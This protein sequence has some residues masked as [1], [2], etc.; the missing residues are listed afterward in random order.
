[1]G[2]ALEKDIVLCIDTGHF[3]P[4]GNVSDKLSSL[5]FIKYLGSMS[6]AVEI[7]DHVILQDDDIFAMAH[8]LVASNILDKQL[9]V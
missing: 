2:Y 5:S 9:L 3:H 6:K 4:S 7:D 8:E 1:M